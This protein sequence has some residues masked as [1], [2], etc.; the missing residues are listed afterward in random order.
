MET[1][2]SYYLISLIGRPLRER[3][4]MNGMLFS[5]TCWSAYSIHPTEQSSWNNHNDMVSGLL[6]ACKNLVRSASGVSSGREPAPRHGQLR[7]EA[8]CQL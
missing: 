3:L 2:Q 6:A 5:T 1:V 4:K 8:A 7:T